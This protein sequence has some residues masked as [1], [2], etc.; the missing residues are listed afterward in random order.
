MNCT[1]LQGPSL[2]ASEIGRADDSPRRE[3]RPVRFSADGAMTVTS[4]EQWAGDFVVHRSAQAA[5]SNR[6]LLAPM[7]D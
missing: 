1:A 5:P 4:K 7:T 2:I 6:H 3:R